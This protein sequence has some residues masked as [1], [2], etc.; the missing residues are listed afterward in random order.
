MNLRH[1]SSR[2]NR[3]NPTMASRNRLRPLQLLLKM[4]LL[5][6]RSTQQD[7]A[8][9]LSR[10]PLLNLPSQPMARRLN[11]RLQPLRRPIPESLNKDRSHPN[12]TMSYRHPSLLTRRRAAPKYLQS[13]CLP[14]SSFQRQLILWIRVLDRRLQDSR[15]IAAPRKNQTTKEPQQIHRFRRQKSLASL[16]RD[17]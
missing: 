13:R 17:P 7:P 4:E 2:W 15:S 6:A 9:D 16:A 1:R 12:R 8:L 10:K 11:S 14:S 5:P 3:P